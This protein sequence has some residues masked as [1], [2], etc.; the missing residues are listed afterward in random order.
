MRRILT[1][2]L[3]LASVAAFA[4]TPIEVAVDTGPGNQSDPHV[5]A[6]RI[7]YTDDSSTVRVIRYYDLS[8][9]LGGT[10]P[11]GNSLSDNLSDISGSVIVFTRREGS[12]RNIY[13]WNWGAA[14]ASPI[15]F[16]A[17]ANRQHAAIGNDTVAWE[18][19]T[20]GIPSTIAV[21]NLTSSSLITLTDNGTNTAPAVSPAGDLVVWTNCDATCSIHSAAA[22]GGWAVH[23]EATGVELDSTADTNGSVIVYDA[24]GTTDRDIFFKPAGGSGTP[25]E[26]SAGADLNPNIA[27]NLVA[28]EHQDPAAGNARDIWVYDI[29]NNQKYQ[30]TNS[31]DDE[32][33]NDISIDGN[34]VRVVYARP[35]PN[36]TG[37]DDVY[38]TSFPLQAQTCEQPPAE[39][40]PA[41][42]CA[43]LEG[44]ATPIAE[45]TVSRDNGK[46]KS[47]ETTTTESG[48]AV[49]CVTTE[50][51]ASAHV[52]QNSHD[53]FGPSSFNP[54]VTSL[55]A[56]T[57]LSG[58]DSFSASIASAPGSGVTVRVYS[59]AA[60]CPEGGGTSADGLSGGDG[61]GTMGCSASGSGL[62][63]WVVAL[64]ALGTMLRR[65][66]AFARSRK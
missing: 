24:L 65:R 44:N 16:L 39:E 50:G 35:K 30:L 13:Q 64:L 21:Y 23:G 25:I 37:D 11:T 28:F 27:G 12:A 14:T 51:T 63:A 33:L 62:A 8:T 54:H 43:L 42:A 7:A 53:V 15:A 29:A 61:D 56:Y 22:G 59:L 17:N 34:T 36:T 20:G 46:P 55:A 40:L 57:T 66:R 48:Q 5:S 45:L 10:V 47:A 49:I 60:L 4:S 32:R 52:A 26:M 3:A 41:D 2:A 38:A 6:S 18:D 9:S 19:R 58:A 1:A 31:P